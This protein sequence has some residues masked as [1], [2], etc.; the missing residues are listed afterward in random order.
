MITES[1][2]SNTVNELTAHQDK[3]PKT[4]NAKTREEKAIYAKEY[5]QKN[6]EHIAQRRKIYRHQNKE[7]IASYAKS[8]R[9]KNK[10]EI[11]KQIYE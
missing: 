9:E 3:Q 1:A 4:S 7:A 5:Y 8:Y 2:E 11:L 6:K 10:A